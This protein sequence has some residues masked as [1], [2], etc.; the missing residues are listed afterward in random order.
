MARV[1]DAHVFVGASIQ[2]FGLAPDAAAAE[3][4]R[5]EVDGA[6]IVPVRPAGYAYAPENDRVA[7]AARV[8]A[9]RFIGLGRV[10]PRQADAAEEAARC[11]A[12]LGLRGIFV[13]PFEDALAISSPRLDPVLEVCAERSAPLMVAA[14]HPWVSE[15]PQIA[16]LALRHPS[17]PIV[18]TNGGQ[19]N[20]SGLG[21]CNAWLAMEHNPNV[22]M[23]TSGVYREDFI[24]EVAT[25]LGAARVM[26]GSQSPLFDMDMELHRLRWAH[27]DDAARAAMLWDTAVGVFGGLGG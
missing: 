26:F 18:M 5:L 27:V 9:D 17:V 20:I 3:L 1:L 10:D 2:G 15:A 23:T 14:G 21:Q 7:E 16:E 24:E 6:V 22:Y 11:L 4:D 8:R 19:I 13:H 12:E 25:G